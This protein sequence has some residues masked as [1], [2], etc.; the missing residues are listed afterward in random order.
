MVARAELVQMC[1]ELDVDAKGASI[2]EMK[3]LIKAEADVRFRRKYRVGADSLSCALKKFLTTEYNY[4][5]KDEE[6]NIIDHRGRKI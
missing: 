5:L 1:K 4:V 3:N 2:E 6:G